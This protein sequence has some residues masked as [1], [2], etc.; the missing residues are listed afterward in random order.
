MKNLRVFIVVDLL[1]SCYCF[2]VHS[3]K[4]HWE[5]RCAIVPPGS[6]LVQPSSASTLS[7]V[8]VQTSAAGVA[9]ILSQLALVTYHAHTTFR[10]IIEET[11]ATSARISELQARYEHLQQTVVAAKK[12]QQREDTMEVMKALPRT[13]LELLDQ[14]RDELL[15]PASIPPSLDDT[16]KRWIRR[17]C[18]FSFLQVLTSSKFRLVVSTQE[19]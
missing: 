17:F 19:G 18:I 3:Q 2:F 7:D 4:K 5:M 10:D 13:R 14:E 8:F 12:K 6:Q 15:N 1:Q 11:Q 16:L 9:G